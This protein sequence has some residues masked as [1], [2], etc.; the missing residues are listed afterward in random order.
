MLTTKYTW[1]QTHFL[2]AVEH[3]IGYKPDT[4]KKSEDPCT[5]FT[6]TQSIGPVVRTTIVK[7][8]TQ[9][10]QYTSK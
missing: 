9:K 8:I 6:A 4:V 5:E 7:T 3:S 10:G 2:L 1:R